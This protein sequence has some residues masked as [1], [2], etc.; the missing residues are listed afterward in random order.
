MRRV[1][2]FG[3]VA[4]LGAVARAA[5]LAPADIAGLCANAEDQAHCGRLVEERQ[6]K[7]LPG[8]AVRDG[9]DLRVSLYPSG[10]A[11]FRDVVRISGAQTYAL[12]DALSPIN[13]VLLFTTDA[14]RSGFLLLTRNNGRQY[15]LPS[16]PVL[17]PD[18]QYLVTADF[19]ADG[20]DN[21][22]ALWRVTRDDV[23]KERALRPEAAWSDVTAEWRTPDRLVIE[24]KRA[25][26]DASIRD[27]LTLADARWR[28]AR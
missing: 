13:G 28:P 5:P 27:E 16:E 11:V 19:C 3:V 18:R 8:L 24:H 21:E 26:D 4:A 12:W 9:D 7:A 15:R 6:L 14:D 25:G 23:R 10:T 22:L 2:V 20:C 17:S 1:A